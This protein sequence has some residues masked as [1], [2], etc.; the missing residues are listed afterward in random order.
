MN[1]VKQTTSRVALIA[2]LSAAPVLGYAQSSDTNTTTTEQPMPNATEGTATSDTMTQTDTQTGSNTMSTDTEQG[3]T[4]DGTAPTMTEEGQTAQDA[5]PAEMDQGQAATDTM[6]ATDGMSNDTA[7][8]ADPAQTTDESMATADTEVN[9]EEMAKP[10]EGQITMQSDNTVLAGNLIGSS[11]YSA[12]GD[13]IGEIDDLIVN[14]DGNVEGV[15]IGVGGFLGIGEKDVAIEMASLSTTT[16]ENGN[17]RLMSSATKADLEAAEAFMT[18]EDQN[19][20]NQ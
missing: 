7:Q 5:A 15:V 6:P 11:V 9:T 19:A 14:L 13:S 17:V 12:D 18:A 2:L 16:D 1:T 20:M 8:S 10:V 4:A 3:Q